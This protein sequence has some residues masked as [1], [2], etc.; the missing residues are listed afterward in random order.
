MPLVFLHKLL[1]DEKRTSALRTTIKTPLNPKE[2][3][4]KPLVKTRGSAPRT[5]LVR[6]GGGGLEG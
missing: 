5:E 2:G 3:L 1:M 4:A 6:C